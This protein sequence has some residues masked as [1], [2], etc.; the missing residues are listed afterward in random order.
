MKLLPLFIHLLLPFLLLLASPA[1]ARIGETLAECTARYGDP[2]S[3]NLDP[4]V[5]MHEKAGIRVAC[6]YFEG[7]CDFI[8]FKNLKTDTEGTPMPF[9]DAERKVLFE[10]SSA[11][12]DWTPDSEEDQ[13]AYWNC[14]DLQG[15][16]QQKGER[17]IIIQTRAHMA[18]SAASKTKEQKAR[19][20]LKDF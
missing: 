14:D 12:K 8:Y 16:Q 15:L 11:G 18:R 6:F 17:H 7:K 13:V 20:N 1:Q 3:V 9:T 19:E 4:P 10:A 5:T 2:V